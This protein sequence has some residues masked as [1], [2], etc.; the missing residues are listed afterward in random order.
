M[1]SEWEIKVFPQSLL[2]E[3]ETR[4]LIEE[5]YLVVSEI[6][7]EM[8]FFKESPVT[9]INSMAGIEPVKVSKR[10]VDIIKRAISFSKR[11]DGYFD[12]TYPT[13]NALHRNANLIEIDEQRNT[14][15]LPYK[16]MQISLGGI[17]KGFAVDEAY[18]YLS[19]KG[20]VNFLV[21][22]SG[23][24]RCHSHH[25]A[26]R[27]WNLGI[28]NPFSPDKTIGVVK[29]S[30]HAMAT[31]GTYKKGQH[32]RTEEVGTPISV[33]IFG[34]STEEC[35][36]WGTYLC[37]LGCV[38]ALKKMNDENLMGVIIDSSGNC[39]SSKRTLNSQESYKEQ[40]HA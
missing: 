14:I 22:G 21:N 29:L 4:N 24:L 19:S 7:N 2:R 25:S 13:K 40:Y 33:T 31:S 20:L 17:G 9:K 39:Y 5:A 26:P 34:E 32:I 3:D 1:N 16:E 8:S 6:E 30:N 11:T 38:E 35:D 15:F 27:A 37:S 12:I 10:L 23:D 36:I 28:S 18:R